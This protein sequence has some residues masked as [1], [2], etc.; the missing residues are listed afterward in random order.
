MQKIFSLLTVGVV[1]CLLAACDMSTPSNMNV[2]KIS[3]KES[4]VTKTFDAYNFDEAEANR[5]AKDYMNNSRG[6]MTITVSYLADK[7]DTN[8][9]TARK[10]AK[11][12]KSNFFKLGVENV[13][14]TV[15]P[16]TERKHAEKL[17]VSYKTLV[18]SAPK[19]C[20]SIIGLDGAE[21]MFNADEYQFGCH[22]KTAISKM[23][24]DPA[25]LLGKS[26][27]VDAESRRMGVT[28]ER[29]KSGEANKPIKGF[30]AS[31]IGVK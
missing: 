21:T 5:I 1:I 3:V 10:N 14:I 2:S 22:T 8:K 7:N 30:N 20:S 31:D 12:F 18:A 17:V 23:I 6:S 11:V 15:V 13:S 4:F 19:E 24:V 25:D 27:S 26:G 9:V 29:F 16:V 28:V